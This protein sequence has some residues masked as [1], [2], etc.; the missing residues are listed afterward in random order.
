MLHRLRLSN[1]KGFKQASIPLGQFTMLVGANAA[2]KSNVRDALRFLHGLSRGYSL[3][4]VMGERWAEGGVLQWKGLRGG[5][6]EAAFQG[7]PAFEL[8]IEL[9]VA[10]PDDQTHKLDYTVEVTLGPQREGPRISK[11][12]LYLDDALVFDSHRGEEPPKQIDDEHIVVRLRRGGRN[13]RLGAAMAFLSSKPVLTQIADKD[14]LDHEV[15][16]AAVSACLSTMQRMRFFELTPDSMRAPSIPGQVELGLRGENLSSVLM[17]ICESPERKAALIA[18][19]QDFAA[20]KI[21]DLVFPEDYSGKVLLHLVEDNG[22][23]VSAHS[24]S[25]G[26][27]RFL[28]IFA[29]MSEPDTGRFFFFEELE[30]SIHPTRLKLVLG[31]IEDKCAAG[32]LQ[33]AITSQSAQLLALASERS[34]A[35][36]ILIH[37]SLHRAD[38]QAIRLIDL[39]DIGRVFATRDLGQLQV[40]GWLQDSIEY[41][42]T[43]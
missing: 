35:S 40:C 36:A 4:E 32:A 34:R 28:A 12:A 31:L 7:A 10:G 43:L 20:L 42:S 25:A 3:S 15:V 37:R 38:A 30:N 26:L 16:K 14:A 11:E 17:G 27:L 22:F 19:I 23:R 24:A 41:L 5:T 1:F 33:V 18:S 2:G 29:A 6:R 21:R 8:G 13:R 39:P 9:K